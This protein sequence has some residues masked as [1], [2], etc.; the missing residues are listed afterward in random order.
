[1]RLWVIT[2]CILIV[3]KA[4]VFPI[5]CFLIFQRNSYWTCLDL[6]F[7]FFLFKAL[8]A[9]LL[10]NVSLLIML[11]VFVL[12]FWLFLTLKRKDWLCHYCIPHKLVSQHFGFYVGVKWLLR[13]WNQ[14]VELWSLNSNIDWPV[15]LCSLFF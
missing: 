11:I 8:L 6:C 3:Y 1:M 7:P 14:Y 13:K 4:V 10:T 2:K 15:V 9:K 5:V 12:N